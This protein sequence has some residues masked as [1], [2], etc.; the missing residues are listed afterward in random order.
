MSDANRP[1]D[2]TKTEQ[3]LDL[4]LDALLERQTARRRAADAA[5]ADAA[6]AQVASPAAPSPAQPTAAAP[7]A[8][9]QAP[10]VAATP[11][12]PVTEPRRTAP[13]R[14]RAPRRPAPDEVGWTPA[15]PVPSIHLH[16]I[17]WRLLAFVLAMALFI[18]IPLTRHGV[19]LAR[20]L[21][22]SDALVIRD[23]L[24][25]KG[26]GP[27]IYQLQDDKLRWISSM[28]AFDA[29]GL[30]WDDVHVV[31]E[32]LLARFEQGEPI[33]VLVGCH[34]SPHIFLHEGPVKRWIKDIPTFRDRGYYWEDIHWIDCDA[35]RDIPDGLPIG[36]N[37][38]TP[39]QP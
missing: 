38:G 16:R 31:D 35:L 18:N 27:E 22:D 2:R 30:T 34:D 6:R 25:L 9:E 39:P 10:A 21:P 29:L 37:A 15:E 3:I 32:Q 36:D 4:L 33:H 26:P 7:A 17:L 19:S 13:P 11:R 14:E 23:G 20:L 1:D 28:D 24:V 12:P 8:P 5:R